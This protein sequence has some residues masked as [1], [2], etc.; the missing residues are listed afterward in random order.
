MKKFEGIRLL[1]LYVWQ[2]KQE[3][4]VS[5][6]CNTIKEIFIV[7]CILLHVLTINN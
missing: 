4:N 7:V 3:N 1:Y 2:R 6:I 5:R